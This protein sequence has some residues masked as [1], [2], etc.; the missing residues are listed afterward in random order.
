MSTYPIKNTFQIIIFY[1][2]LSTQ[3]YMSPSYTTNFSIIQY[4][5]L[6]VALEWLPQ[7]RQPSLPLPAVVVVFVTV[8]VHGRYNV[9]HC[10]C[11]CSCSI[12]SADILAIVVVVVPVYLVVPGLHPV[13]VEGVYSLSS[14][15]PLPLLPPPFDYFFASFFAVTFYPSA[16]ITLFC[17]TF[18]PPSTVPP[19]SYPP[20]L[21]IWVFSCLAETF[22]SAVEG[23]YSLHNVVYA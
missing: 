1:L 23:I 7:Q 15:P 10:C 11:R 9:Y 3:Y 8:E 2:T 5:R 20:K 18:P 6:I 21:Y 12:S 19:S 22:F 17:V 16:S 14:Q 13:K 4:F